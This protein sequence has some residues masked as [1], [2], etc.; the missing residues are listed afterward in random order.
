HQGGDLSRVRD[1][2]D[3]LVSRAL[4]HGSYSVANKALIAQAQLAT[5][6]GRWVHAREGFERIRD[7]ARAQRDAYDEAF[8]LVALVEVELAAIDVREDGVPAALRTLLDEAGRAAEAAGLP[9]SGAHLRCVEAQLVGTLGRA[10]EAAEGYA[11]CAE[12]FDDL[13]LLRRAL[14][15]HVWHALY[16]SLAGEPARAEALAREIQPRARSLGL[17]EVG[18]WAGYVQVVAALDQGHVE[19]ALVHAAE[20][21]D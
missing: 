16:L 3:R 21:F 1:A 7:R 18:L 5:R 20:C 6:Q 14:G 10:R 9:D 17:R 13:G 12:A 2:Y 11:R 15:A 4:E 8:A 19:R